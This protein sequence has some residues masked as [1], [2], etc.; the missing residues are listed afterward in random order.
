MATKTVNNFGV[1]TTLA[2]DDK[3]PVWDTSA[4]ATKAITVANFQAGLNL[5]DYLKRDG[6]VAMSGALDMGGFAINNV[7]NVDGV[8]VS[9]LNSNA[10]LKAGT[11]ALTGDWDIGAGRAISA[12]KL[13]ARSAS[14]L[15]LEDDAGTLG[16][17]IE[18]ATGEVGIGTATPAAKLDVN[19]SVR[20]S[21]DTDTASYFGRAAIGFV[22][23]VSDYAYFGH[24][25][26][27]FGN[28]YAVIQD[29]LGQTLVNSAVGKTL[30]LRQANV[31]RFIINADGTISIVNSLQVGYDTNLTSYFGRAAV[32]YDGATSDWASFAHIDN[33]AAASFALSQSNAGATWLNA[34][35][36]QPIIFSIA[37]AEKMRVASDGKVS[38]GNLAAP[39]LLLHVY[40]GSAGTVTAHANTNMVVESNANAG[41]SILAPDANESHIVFGRASN[42]IAAGIKLSSTTA[43]ELVFLRSDVGRAAIDTSGNFYPFADNSYSCGKSGKRWTA[44]W[45]VNG[46]IQ[47]S[48]ERDKRDVAPTTLGLEFINALRPVQWRWAEAFNGGN[49]PDRVHVGLSAQQV[50]QVIEQQ[51]VED[52]GGYWYDADGDHHA[53]AY[54]EFIAPLINAVQQLSK[55]VEQLLKRR[56]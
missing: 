17:F 51:G 55:Q 53:L 47:T 39:D 38:I 15:R 44:V 13:R 14:G 42:N 45:A 35:T 20:A 10:L 23:T 24:V 12:E 18:D 49:S 16:I 31:D 25:D 41:V 50:K 34:K 56:N 40:A 37:T 19:G 7:G 6:T 9:T 21:Y 33:N 8:D 26:Q 43:D 3:V 29:S 2:S 32:G 54:H 28:T 11:V 52:F 27:Q 1:I 46:T 36:G 48:D 4:A 5:T 30:N 22:T